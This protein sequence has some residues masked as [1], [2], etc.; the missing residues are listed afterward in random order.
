MKICGAVALFIV[1]FFVFCTFSC[2]DSG[3]WRLVWSDEFDYEGEPDPGKWTIVQKHELLS[4]QE[5]Q[6]YEDKRENVRVENG[7]LIIQAHNK[8]GNWYTSGRLDTYLSGK[9]TYG[10]IEVKARL[11]RGRGTWPAIFMTASEDIKNG[12][13]WPASG[14]IEIM[15]H[16]GHNPGRIWA[17]VECYENNVSKGNYESGELYVDDPFN[18]FHIYAVEWYPDRLDF[19]VDE[20]KY[21]T[22]ENKMRD[23]K[24]WPFYRDFYLIICLAI[25]DS[26]G[27]ARGVDE[28]V[29]PVQMVIDYV[30]VYQTDLKKL[31]YSLRDYEAVE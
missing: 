6:S 22:Y 1:L 19:Y 27:G 17:A 31:G 23:W 18:E 15:E 24:T 28:S 14:G 2:S 10:R 26:Q 30:R 5:K 21:F 7:T 13:G 20:N 12:Y 9:W 3:I 11:P 29:F 4:S 16:E 8:G 25:S